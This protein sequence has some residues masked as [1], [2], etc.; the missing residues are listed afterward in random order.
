M[1]MSVGDSLQPTSPVITNSSSIVDWK[2]K[3]KIPSQH[4]P[5]NLMKV[6]V[7]KS[8][9]DSISELDQVRLATVSLPNESTIASKFARFCH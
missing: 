5:V 8:F 2:K 1:T 7:R 4:H 3:P 9:L 6:D